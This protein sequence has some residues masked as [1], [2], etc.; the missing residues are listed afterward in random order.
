MCVLQRLRDMGMSMI[1]LGLLI[2]NEYGCGITDILTMSLYNNR[3]RIIGRQTVWWKRRLTLDL[4]I[5][6]PI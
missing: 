5:M 6:R 4:D 3:W 2:H 1:G